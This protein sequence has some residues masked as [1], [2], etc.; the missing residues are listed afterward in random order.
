[1]QKTCSS[2]VDQI[3]LELREHQEFNGAFRMGGKEN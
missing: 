3:E 2:T 1:M